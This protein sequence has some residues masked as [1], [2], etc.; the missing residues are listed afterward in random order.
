MPS[1]L[2]NSRAS[3]MSL[4]LTGI[5]DTYLDQLGVKFPQL[6]KPQ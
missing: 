2:T 5:G 6:T 1:A 3:S 4:K